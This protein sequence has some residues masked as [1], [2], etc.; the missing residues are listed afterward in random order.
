A[1]TGSAAGARSWHEVL[2]PYVAG[3]W[4]Q[5]ELTVNYRTP[6]ELMAVA[7]KVLA[8]IDPSLRAPQSV[9]ETGVEA[10]A[11]PMAAL[12]ALV[13]A[14]VGEGGKV[15]VIVPDAL[16]T[17]IASLIPGASGPGVL[18]APVAVLGVADAKGLEFD[19]VI[20][21][22]PDLIAAQSP[23]GLSDLYVALT[24]ATQR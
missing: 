1:Q 16:V 6:V 4:N 7:A 10:W 15:A 22:E 9:R 14:E 5:H 12:E 19:S 2:D 20:V 11:A 8:D 18:D 21:C 23:R 13:K 3:R 17:S 24:R